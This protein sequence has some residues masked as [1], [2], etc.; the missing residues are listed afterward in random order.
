M[1]DR[2]A[3][4]GADGIDESGC[5][6][7]GAAL[8]HDA[9]GVSAR[10][11]LHV[12]GSGGVFGAAIRKSHLDFLRSVVDYAANM[13][14]GSGHVKRVRATKMQH[15]ELMRDRVSATVKQST[16]QGIRELMVPFE[17]SESGVVS[18][19]LDEGVRR[20]LP[21]PKGEARTGRKP[22]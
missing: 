13:R 16:K 7:A 11:L 15:E 18:K 6:D 12:G 5:A 9:I 1:R 20:H 21:K 22:A 8:L 4:G 10:M 2:S 19:L 14:H 3:T 17:L